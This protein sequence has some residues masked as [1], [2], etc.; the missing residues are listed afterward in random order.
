MCYD[1]AQWKVLL[2]LLLLASGYT[3]FKTKHSIKNF[4]HDYPLSLSLSLSLFEENT[5]NLF[6]AYNAIM[7]DI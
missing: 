7:V 5:K 2:L 4:P 3:S 6:V 1:N